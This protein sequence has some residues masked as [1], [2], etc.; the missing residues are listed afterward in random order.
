MDYQEYRGPNV[1][2]HLKSRVHFQ[3]PL[4]TIYEHIVVAPVDTNTDTNT[5]TNNNVQL[6]YVKLMHVP[7][8]GLRYTFPPPNECVSTPEVIGFKIGYKY[9]LHIDVS[10]D[11]STNK[12][13]N[14]DFLFVNSL[15]EKKP[16]FNMKP[17]TKGFF[18]LYIDD[19]IPK[20][21]F[22]M[23]TKDIHPKA[24]VQ[25]INPDE[26]TTPTPTPT[27]CPACPSCPSSTPCPSC[28][29]PTP[30]P[31]CPTPIPCPAPSP[32]K[33]KFWLLLGGISG[34]LLLI[35]IIGLILILMHNRS[36]KN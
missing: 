13:E 31:S 1:R 19:T 18:E 12:P 10:K 35:L 25:I 29:S 26:L 23:S 4:E 34:G 8:Y 30:C 20:Q 27:P 22:A 5:N 6:I 24:L 32:D 36:K 33:T 15:T 3:E 17:I 11:C 14:Q 21:F 9:R 28:P 7:G 16:L 2:N